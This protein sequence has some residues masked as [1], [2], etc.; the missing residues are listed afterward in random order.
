MDTILK[1]GP[2]SKHVNGKASHHFDEAHTIHELKHFLPSQQA[3]KD[4]IHHNS[5]H[6]FQH[7]KF[8]DAIFKASKIFGFQVHLQLGEYRE[9]YKTGRIR[10]DVLQMVIANKKGREAVADWKQKLIGKDYDTI[11][12][13]RIGQLR[14]YWKDIYHLDLDNKVHPLLF[15]ILCA[16]LD[17]GIAVQDFP[18]ANESFTESIKKLE[19]NS[20]TSFFKTKAVKQK[21]LS[22][23]YSMTEL[24]KNI[25]GKEEYFEQYLFDQ[26]FA[27]HGW[28]G[29]ASA[30]EDNPQTLLDKKLIT[31]KELVEFELLMELDA[32][33]YNL[34][35]N[36]KPLTQHITEPPLDLF[37]GVSKTEFAEVIE[38]WQD[39]FEWSYYD[40]VLKGITIASPKALTNDKT[41][42]AIFCIDER[43]DSIR[44][45]IEAVDRKSET[46]GA[47]GFFGVEF[48]FQQE[49][50]KFY[51]KLCP[52]PVTPKYL[53]KEYNAKEPRKGEPIYTK[54][55]HEFFTGFVFKYYVWFLGSRKK[56]AD[57]FQSEN[58]PGYFQ[59]IWSYGQAICSYY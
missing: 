48:Y 16:F 2:L 44:R 40:S 52:A 38:L 15:R 31:L 35:K 41:F 10:R 33:N 55:T 46:F 30:V 51:D 26:Q 39:A 43:E 34:G 1:P 32:L 56:I 11:N 47:P 8:Y 14:K 36:W 20:F 5:L 49:G 45:H 23:N 13:P 25:V 42:Q 17:Q 19:E 53:I 3:L 18:I 6:A 9:M 24:L 58:E 4:F 22:G 37:A 21:F 27:H 12:H 7:M 54:L 57:A 28:S 59:C 29:F 50:S